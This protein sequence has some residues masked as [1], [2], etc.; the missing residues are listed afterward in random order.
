VFKGNVATAGISFAMS[1]FCFRV[2]VPFMTDKVCFA[3]AT[4]HLQKRDERRGGGSD[5]AMMGEGDDQRT[6]AY[7][8]VSASEVGRS[9]QASRCSS[10]DIPLGIS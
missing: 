7:E 2:P 8:E 4:L 6:H 1:E 10:L 5:G 3:L 9:A